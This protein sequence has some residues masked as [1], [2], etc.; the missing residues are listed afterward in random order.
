MKN[1]FSILLVALALLFVASAVVGCSSG[2]S[3]KSTIARRTFTA[4]NNPATRENVA[5]TTSRTSVATTTSSTTTTT[6]AKSTEP[7]KIGVLQATAGPLAPYGN[8]FLAGAKAAVQMINDA[9][10]INGVQVTFVTGTGDGTAKTAVAEAERLINTEKVLGI[11]GPTSTAEFLA[12]TEPAEKYKVPFIASCA[13]QTVFAKGYRFIF[14]PAP[15]ATVQGA[16]EA[17]FINW[18][19]KNNGVKI[20]SIAVVTAALGVKPYTDAMMPRLTELGYT[21]IVVNEDLTAGVTDMNPV[22]LK[23]KTANPDVV[24]YNGTAADGILFQKAL[25]ANNY[26]PLLVSAGSSFG[27]AARD[28]LGADAKGLLTRPN[29]FTVGAS[30][31]T[32]AYTTVPTLSSFQAIVEKV[33]PGVKYDK[34]MAAAGGQEALMLLKAIA[35]SGSRNSE[36]IAAAIRQL[37]IKNPSPYLVFADQYPELKMGETGMPLLSTLSGAQ[38]DDT[39]TFLQTVWPPSKAST[40]PRLK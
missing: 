25:L 2:N 35:D 23:L 26:N 11:V 8:A 22:V 18:L 13:D 6:A 15:S 20:S 31:V 9:G 3:A 16:G 27:S 33:T 37:D 38:W 14:S 30:I 28:A 34:A 24:V 7:I 29:V 10:G 19:A 32:D 17:D 39:M 36:E 40:K 21:N 1:R 12:C 4:T 5:A